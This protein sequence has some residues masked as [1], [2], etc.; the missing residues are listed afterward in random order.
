MS[1]AHKNSMVVGE[2]APGNLSSD[3]RCML[4]GL[5]LEHTRTN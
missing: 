3:N 4:C 1:S 2:D 5:C